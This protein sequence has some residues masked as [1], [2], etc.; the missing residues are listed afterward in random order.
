MD[1]I[2]TELAR[3]RKSATYSN[4]IA[5]VDSIIEYLELV[6]QSP[7]ES[8]DCT[9]LRKRTSTFVKQIKSHE[10]EVHSGMSRYGKTLDKSFKKSLRSDD[11][12]SIQ[13][14]S[15]N[16]GLP[17]PTEATPPTTTT[18]ARLRFGE[19]DNQLL[20]VD[21]GKKQDKANHKSDQE[22]TNADVLSSNDSAIGSWQADRATINRAI[23]MHLERTGQFEVG[24]TFQKEAD[25]D[26]P[27]QLMHEFESLY[28]IL[29]AMSENDLTPAIQWAQKKRNILL[30]R[31]STLEFVLHK[32]Q[33]FR[34]LFDA[35]VPVR[36]RELAAL[37]YAREHLALFGD[38]YLEE[39]A[40]LMTSVLYV[41]NFD[42]CPYSQDLQSPTLE[43]VHKQF[44]SEFCSVLGLPPQSPLVLAVTAGFIGQP[45]L[46]R[47]NNVIKKRGAEWTTATELPVPIDLPSEFQFHSIFVCPVSK[48]QTTEDNPP[49]M[50]PCGHVLATDSVRSLGKG[51]FAKKFKCPYCPKETCLNEAQRVF[52]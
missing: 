34:L 43:Q 45:V 18:T 21:S 30:N 42:A 44:A 1:A 6:R 40:Q 9:E 14:A 32:L 37:S 33:F 10:K 27:D 13:S 7:P 39:I 16:K 23:L 12:S 49:L 48:E 35:S 28:G 26:I 38:R 20:S 50:L 25:V 5:D 11:S 4:C 17:L 31:G 22:D 29:Q 41:N 47:M 2:E 52:F 3:L 19:V 15:T 46:A 24:T 8:M 36:S 51:Q